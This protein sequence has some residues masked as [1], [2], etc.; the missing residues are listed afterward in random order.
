GETDSEWSFCH[1]MYLLQNL[2]L[3]PGAP[4]SLD[5]RYRAVTEFA[6]K[7]QPLGPAN[8]VYSDGEYLFV[9]GHRRTQPG[10]EGFHPPGLHWLCRTCSPGARH[11]PIPGLSFDPAARIPHQKAVLVASVPLTDE[12]WKP[13][14]EGEILV[15]RRGEQVL[16]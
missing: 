10:R 16:P 12:A 13:L 9:H 6:R 14:G 2:W 3:P 15:F 11:A 8:F 5:R 7:L 4:P 1:L